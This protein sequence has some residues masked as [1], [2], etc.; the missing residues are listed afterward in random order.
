MNNIHWGFFNYNTYNITVI[1]F[2]IVYCNVFK[3]LEHYYMIRMYVQ[4]VRRNHDTNC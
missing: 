4:N 2:K 1:I 3:R